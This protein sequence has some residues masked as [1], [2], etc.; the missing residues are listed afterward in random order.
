MLW[1]GRAGGITGEAARAW[2]DPPLGEGADGQ[3]GRVRGQRRRGDEAGAVAKGDVSIHLV[4]D[5]EEAQLGGGVEELPQ[6]PFAE[7]RPA[8]VARVADDDGGGAC[9]RQGADVGQVSLPA[10]LR[11]EVVEPK[12]HP[13]VL[14]EGLV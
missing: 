13:E 7:H 12:L 10:L 9:I 8:G 14:A 3:D 5:D 4:G 6:V 1:A 2:D 11:Q